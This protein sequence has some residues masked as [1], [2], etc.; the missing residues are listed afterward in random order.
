GRALAGRGN[1]GGAY[2]AGAA[3]ASI[4]ARQ[5][6]PAPVTP[7][8]LSMGELSVLPTHTPTA[9]SVVKPIVQLSRKSLVVPVFAPAGY[10]GLIGVFS[11]KPGMRA[12]LSDRMLCIR[13]AW[14]GSSACVPA[15][16]G[17][18]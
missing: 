14:P 13:Y 5:I 8:T 10:G 9:I 15:G 4:T 3:A 16:T 2:S 17:Y 12:T 6:G 7:V 18:G 1:S 11:P